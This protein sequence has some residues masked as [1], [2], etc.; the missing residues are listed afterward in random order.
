RLAVGFSCSSPTKHA[1][2][3]HMWQALMNHLAPRLIQH[4]PY[5]G[6][7]TTIAV[8]K[9]MA[10]P[11]GGSAQSLLIAVAFCCKSIP[12]ISAITAVSPIATKSAKTPECFTMTTPS[13]T[14][15]FMSPP[16]LPCPLLAR[17]SNK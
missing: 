9:S 8:A 13:D 7:K 12:H 15:S 2:H 1:N 11:L 6:V 5:Q 14:A 17:A 16:P 3:Y 10:D 4:S